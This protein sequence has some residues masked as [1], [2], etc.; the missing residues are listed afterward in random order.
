MSRV[1]VTGGA[2]FIGSHVVDLLVEQNH[3]VLVIDDLSTG[4]RENLR[5]D[6]PLVRLDISTQMIHI[7]D[8]VLDFKTQYILHLAAQAAISTAESNPQVDLRINGIGTL[9]MLEIARLTGVE[10]FILASTS[11]VYLD[12]DQATNYGIS[13]LTAENYVKRMENSVILRLGNVYGPR[14]V[15]IGENQVIAKMIEHM[16]H[17]IP[18]SIHGDGEQ[19]RDFVYVEDVARAFLAAIKG[20]AGIYDIATG[21][22]VSVNDAAELVKKVFGF[23]MVWEHDER[24]DPRRDVKLNTVLAGKFLGWK[25][26]I[27]LEEGVKRTINHLT[28]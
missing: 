22:S 23:S 5:D 17:D 25:A 8:H 4:R 15:P 7:L 24:Y 18:F 14:Q 1:V 20:K 11:A 9:N 28:G 6:V 21:K 12:A 19:K 27:G 10:R 26:E 16:K 13:K 2:G 3:E